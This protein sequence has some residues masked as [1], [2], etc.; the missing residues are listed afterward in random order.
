MPAVGDKIRVDGTL[1]GAK[2]AWAYFDRLWL[3]EYLKIT[4][5]AANANKPY[6]DVAD[7]LDRISEHVTTVP[8]GTMASVEEVRPFPYEG[9]MDVEARVLVTDGPKRGRELWTT[10]AELVDPAGHT[11]LRL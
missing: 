6:Q 5:D 9:R 4:I 3:E 8:N 7:Q 10:C 1:G 2:T 11:Y